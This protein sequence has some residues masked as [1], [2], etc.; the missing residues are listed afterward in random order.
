MIQASKD[1]HGLASEL[2]EKLPERLAEGTIRP[3]SVRLRLGLDAV[4]GEV[5][6]VRRWEDLRLQVSLWTVK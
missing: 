1:G 2:F 3:N 4:F 5:P 6:G